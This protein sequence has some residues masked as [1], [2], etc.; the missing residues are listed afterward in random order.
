[1]VTR[2]TAVGAG[3]AFASLAGAAGFRAYSASAR[4][5]HEE[6]SIDAVLIDETIEIPR[7][8]AALIRADRR[9]G[10]VVGV[11]LDAAGQAGLVRILDESQTIVGVSSGASLFCLERI[12]WDHGFRLTARSQW[13][14]G[15]T[16]V[17][18]CRQDVATFLSGAYPAAA[19]PS[20]LTRA[21]R[22]SRADGT[23][24]AWVMQKSAGPRLGQ[25][26]REV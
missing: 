16:H 24:H 20:P 10:A 12:A 11:R 4:R 19:N 9:A 1:M 21:Y 23:L 7:Q 25:G 6:P 18:A 15:D 13:S 5:P 22:P 2:R 8:L 3:L 26:R 14:A 17:E